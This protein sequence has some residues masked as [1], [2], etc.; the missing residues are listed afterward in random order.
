MVPKY[1]INPSNVATCYYPILH[2]FTKDCM[3]RE[4]FINKGFRVPRSVFEEFEKFE[5]FERSRK[6][7]MSNTPFE[8]FPDI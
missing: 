4:L 6:Y 7:G 5:W 8:E 1:P 2:V 3:S